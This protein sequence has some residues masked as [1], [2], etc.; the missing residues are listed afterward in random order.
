MRNLRSHSHTAERPG[1]AS[2]PSAIPASELGRAPWNHFDGDRAGSEVLA[3]LRL[4]ILNAQCGPGQKLP[5]E[6]DIAAQLRVGRPAVREAI[7]A[8]CMLEVL[9]SRRG[10]GTFVR[11]L[12]A[13][14]DGWPVQLRPKELQFDMIELLEVRRMIEPP[15]AALAAARANPAQLAEMRRCIELQERNLDDAKIVNEQD[16]QF[17]EAIVRAAAN[18]VLL[19]LNQRL[20]PLLVKSRHVT[21]KSAPNFREMLR[22]HRL[23]FEAIR[24]SDPESARRLMRD[25][26]HMVGMDLL[27]DPQREDW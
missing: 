26:L 21:G 2:R 9:D 25:H 14:T 4:L 23:I 13:L 10:A 20:A 3:N 11:S 5:S 22:M 15:A 24:T 1:L 8:L 12:S 19:D 18:Q 6:R 7:K 27:A 17:H 16:F